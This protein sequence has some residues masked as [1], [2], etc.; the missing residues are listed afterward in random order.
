M[1]DTLLE[2]RVCEKPNLLH[3]ENNPNNSK[4]IKS[5]LFIY[6]LIIIKQSGNDELRR[7]D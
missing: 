6:N 2:K 4:A 1:F 3:R 5:N 7:R